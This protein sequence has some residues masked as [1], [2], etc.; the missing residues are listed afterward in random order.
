M[1]VDNVF[2]FTK[3]LQKNVFGQKFL[4]LQKNKNYE[5]LNEKLQSVWKGTK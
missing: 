3:Y 5:T 2:G 1:G 4:V